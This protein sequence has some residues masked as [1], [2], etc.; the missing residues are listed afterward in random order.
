MTTRPTNHQLFQ[1]GTHHLAVLA[2]EQPNAKVTVQILGPADTKDALRCV[3]EHGEQLTV[4]KSKL[5]P[6]RL[7]P[8]SDV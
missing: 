2:D 7:H 3:S 1:P 6:L 4:R 5:K 8:P